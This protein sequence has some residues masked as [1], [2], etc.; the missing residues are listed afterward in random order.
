MTLT[1]IKNKYSQFFLNVILNLKTVT[2]FVWVSLTYDWLESW[3]MGSSKNWRRSK[4]L[5]A[6]Y[7]PLPT[8]SCCMTSLL[9]LLICYSKIHTLTPTVTHMYTHTKIQISDCVALHLQWRW[10]RPGTV[11]L[12]TCAKG[13]LLAS[14]VALSMRM[15]NVEC[16]P[17]SR[18]MPLSSLKL[19]WLIG[20]VGGSVTQVYSCTVKVHSQSHSQLSF[21]SNCR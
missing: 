11:Q 9:T 13:S 14:P 12:L 2:E 21:W 18:P 17:R 7:W 1:T 5:T 6:T 3:K 4:F 15:E 19:N 16:R 8:S 20:K 10:S